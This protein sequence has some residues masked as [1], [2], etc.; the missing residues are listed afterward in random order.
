MDRVG[1]VGAAGQNAVG[2][3]EVGSHGVA[4]WVVGIGQAVNRAAV[5]VAHDAEAAIAASVNGVGGEG[6]IGEG[7]R[8]IQVEQAAAVTAPPR[9]WRHPGRGCR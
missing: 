2:Q 1:P 7:D 3:D 5:G 8:A 6:D 9:R 4:V